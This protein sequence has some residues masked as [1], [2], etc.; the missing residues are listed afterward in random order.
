MECIVAV[1][2]NSINLEANGFVVRS[3]ENIPVVVELN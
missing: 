1:V 2:D 3:L